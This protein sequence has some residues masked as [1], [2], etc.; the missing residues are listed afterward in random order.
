MRRAFSF[1]VLPSL[2]FAVVGCNDPAPTGHPDAAVE[3]FP[4][5]Y[6][7][8]PSP[9]IVMFEAAATA[10][11]RGEVVELRW[12]VEN[13][14]RITIFSPTEIL[15]DTDQLEGVVMTLPVQRRASF[16]IRA[17][18]YGTVGE[19]IDVAAIWPE[20]VIHSFTANP[21]VTYVNGYTM[22]SWETEH[23]EKVS[24]YAND[25]LVPF[26][27]FMGSLAERST[28]FVSIFTEMTTIQIRAENPTHTRTQD[29]LITAGPPPAILSFRADPRTFVG[30]ST[31]VHVTWETQGYEAAEL[32]LNYIPVQGAPRSP[33][34]SYDLEISETSQLTLYGYYAGAPINQ[35]DIVVGRAGV[36]YE[37]NDQPSQAYPI[38]Y[39]GGVQAS[40]G[41]ETDVDYFYIDVYPFNGLGNLKLWVRGVDSGCPVDTM[42]EIYDPFNG[43][44]LG[45]DEDDGIPTGRGGAC[46]EID[47]ERDTFAQNLFGTYL[48]SVRGQRGETG[49]YLLLSEVPVGSGR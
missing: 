12:K 29:I 36:E 48:V 24:I 9:R 25:V 1:L 3:T 46:A 14:Q 11:P 38:G 2:A 7:P 23:A 20:P 33:N 31:I 44:V 30:S 13:A 5:A 34:G 21:E 40:I 27:V 39:E 17:A 6:V 4:D 47:P 45:S 22:V 26:A 32:L 18:G 49:D 15:V 8:P 16:D 10:V 37:P 35:A 42:I 41:S 28:T 43:S 19:T